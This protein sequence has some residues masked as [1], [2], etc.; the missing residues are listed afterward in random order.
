MVSPYF[1]A[2]LFIE[3]KTPRPVPKS[4]RFSF[5]PP[6]FLR[7]FCRAAQLLAERGNDS[8]TM[9]CHGHKIPKW[10]CPRV[11]K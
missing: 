1:I 11:T 3:S 4:R 10:Q 2:G 7:I 8:L 9:L 6:P 5:E